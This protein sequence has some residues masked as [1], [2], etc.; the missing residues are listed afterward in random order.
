MLTRRGGVWWDGDF[1]LLSFDSFTQ[2]AVFVK[3]CGDEWE[4]RTDQYGVEA[5]IEPNADF[6]QSTQGRK[7]G[8]WNRF[9]SVPAILAEK[10]ELDEKIRQGDDKALSKFFNDPEHRKLRTSRGNI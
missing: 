6:E 1:A 7:F 4:I 9:A 2:T 10:Y 8:D 5:A 3:D